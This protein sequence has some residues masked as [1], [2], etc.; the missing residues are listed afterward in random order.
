[1]LDLSQT[2]WVRGRGPKPARILILGE[3]PGAHE[4]Q[5]GYAFVGPSGY[6]LDSWLKEA[7]AP[8]DIIHI[9]NVVPVRPPHN[10]IS[11]VDVNEWRGRLDSLITDVNPEVIIPLGETAL[12]M[13]TGEEQIGK[14]R[15]SILRRDGRTIVPSFHPAFI[16][17]GMTH[18]RW[19]AITDIRKALKE[20]E[21]PHISKVRQ[22]IVEPS[23]MEVVECLD[24]LMGGRGSLY[25]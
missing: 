24:R 8:L 4:E 9:N 18:M 10:D 19:V 13:V 22:F 7:Q 5:K 23:L 16:L 15:G 20:L 6:E 1:M 11:Q 25:R 2:K 12:N 3:A 21:S 14:W 17:R